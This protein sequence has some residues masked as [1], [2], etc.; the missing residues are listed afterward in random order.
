MANKNN[1]KEHQ[2]ILNFVKQKKE[3]F[4]AQMLLKED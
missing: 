2:H 1:K 4:Y 3:F